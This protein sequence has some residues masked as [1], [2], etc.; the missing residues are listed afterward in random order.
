M[1]ALS[2][3]EVA[4]KVGMRHSA[5]RYYE[6]EGLLPS[7]PRSG[8]KRAFDTHAVSRLQVIRTA[9][10][11][12]FSL[13][14]IRQLLTSFPADTPPPERWRTLAREKLPEIDAQIQRALA[15]RR[16]L[17]AGMRCEC[18][19]IDDCFIDDCSKP[20]GKKAL[21]IVPLGVRGPIG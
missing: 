16:M 19:S 8:G 13:E 6:S 21:P 20:T 2:I 4:N 11:L 7:P 1:D 12:G 17:Q 18:V 9:R 14:E 10:E 3:G 5:I 15:L